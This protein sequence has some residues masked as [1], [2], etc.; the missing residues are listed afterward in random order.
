MLQITGEKLRAI[1]Y[2]VRINHRRIVDMSLMESRPDS[3]RAIFYRS[4]SDLPNEFIERLTMV[5]G[6]VSTPVQPCFFQRHVNIFHEFG[7]HEIRVM[8]PV[9]LRGTDNQK[10]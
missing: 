2:Q 7:G 4:L 8:N 9:F 6:I 3:I 5:L 1:C 10:A